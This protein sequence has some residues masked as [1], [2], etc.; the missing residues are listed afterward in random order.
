ML[1]T[2][3]RFEVGICESKE[4]FATVTGVRRK[5]ASEKRRLGKPIYFYWCAVCEG[6]HITSKEVAKDSFGTKRARDRACA[7]DVLYRDFL[8]QGD[9][10]VCQTDPEVRVERHG[11]RWR[12]TGRTAN[13]MTPFRA[14]NWYHWNRKGE[15]EDEEVVIAEE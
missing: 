1:R 12:L 13:H 10:W 3:S 14:I 4:R 6:W 2:I 9:V 5:A 7:D 8:R 15:E 11:N